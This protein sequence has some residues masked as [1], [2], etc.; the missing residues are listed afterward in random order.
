MNIESGESSPRD[1]LKW[2]AVENMA[3]KQHIP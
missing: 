3:I 2:T 1:V